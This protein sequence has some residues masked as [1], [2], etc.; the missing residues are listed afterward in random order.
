MTTSP[1]S[2]AEIPVQMPTRYDND[3]KRAL[4]DTF[5]RRSSSST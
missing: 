2:S 3:T 1:T 4:Q 5:N